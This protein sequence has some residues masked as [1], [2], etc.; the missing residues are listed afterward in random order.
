MIELAAAFGAVAEAL[1]RLN[2]RYVVVG[3]AAAAGW[4]IARMTRDIDLVAVLDVASVASLLVELDRTDLY[5]PTSAASAAA[6]AGGSFNVLHPATGGKVGVFVIPPGDE[7]E[8]A[9]LQRRVRA[10]VFGI[11]SWISTPEDVVLSKLRWRLDSRSDV[12][13]RDCVEIAAIQPLDRGYLQRWAP[14]LGVVDDL[15]DLLGDASTRPE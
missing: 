9:R 5:V 8:H 15:V 14:V 13:W 12:Q 11:Q 7:F 10:E 2:V 4:G 6:V 1:D 3:S